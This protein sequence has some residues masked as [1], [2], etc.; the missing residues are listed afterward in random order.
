MQTITNPHDYSVIGYLDKRKVLAVPNSSRQNL[1]IL[2]EL[3]SGKSSILRLLIY[4]DIIANR[5]FLLAEN[6]SELSREV[7]SMIPPDQHHKIVY[8]SLSSIRQ[9]DKTLRFNPL[10]IDDPQD[11]GMI[12]LNFTECLAKAFADSWGARVETCARN[13]AL[14][15]IGTQSNTIGAML[16]LLTDKEFRQTFIPEINNKQARDFFSHVYAEQ[17]PK[18]A[19]GV[20]FNKLNKMLTIPEMDAMFNTKK[21]SVSFL[22]IINNDM[23]V[24]LDFGGL[25]NDMV[26]FLGNV[27]LHLFYTQYKKR[28]KNEFGKYNTFNLYLDEVQ[29]FS[30]P[31]IRELLNTV[32]KYG[33][34]ATIATQSITAVGKEL[35]EEIMT[36]CRA[37]ACFRCDGTTAHHLKSILPIKPEDQQQLSFHYFSYYGAGDKPIRAVAKTKHMNIPD[38]S[39]TAAKTSVMNLGAFVSLDKYYISQGGNLDVILSPLEFGILNLL[40][41][42]NRDMTKQEITEKIRH[43]YAADPRAITNALNDTLVATNSFAAIKDIMTDDGDEKLESRYVITKAA[44]ARIF[45]HAAAGRRAGGDLHL[46]TIFTIMDLQTNLY[47]YCIPDLGKGSSQKADLLIFSPK[48][49]KPKDP[50]QQILQNTRFHPNEWS[51]KVIAVEVETAPGK[52]W[53]Q[54]YNNYI[55]NEKSGYFPWFVVFDERAKQGIHDTLAEHGVSATNYSILVYDKESLINADLSIVRS[56][57][58]TCVWKVIMD[59]RGSSMKQICE[60]LDNFTPVDL[61][62]AV[63]H[64]TE[65]GVL[66]RGRNRKDTFDVWRISA[67]RNISRPDI[68]GTEPI[69][70][71]TPEDKARYHIEK[72]NKSRENL[73]QD[74]V[75][76]SECNTI[77]HAIQNTDQDTSN[78][79]SNDKQH[80]DQDTSQ[81]DKVIE[82]NIDSTEHNSIYK[83]NLK[84]STLND[85]MI[86]TDTADTTISQDKTPNEINDEITN[87]ITDIR[88]RDQYTTDTQLRE[89]WIA[90]HDLTDPESQEQLQHIESELKRRGL[91][92]KSRR[93]RFFVS[94]IPKNK[95]TK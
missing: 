35:S 56:D 36:L 57:I 84:Q 94:K 54:I 18:E 51:D 16:K 43:R 64:M 40:R 92:I 79:T 75:Q 10:E 70:G 2:G 12:A 89:Y 78:D 38:N 62:R 28:S 53:D 42:E 63:T 4:Q 17:Y 20:I 50:K 15:V 60:V 83:V 21:S 6:H 73:V 37:V 9:Y 34:K 5:G 33:I 82:H 27:F 67:M 77:Q 76:A 23:Y 91:M 59:N 46:R 61:K 26:M 31:M 11:A 65:T 52:H 71:T 22:D 13:G 68:F 1:L 80:T 55:K 41:M 58:E 93:G 69:P 45:S 7:L 44:H 88:D 49:I 48:E 32:R 47:C 90:L 29:M 95:K 72:Q 87:E 30:P 8:V 66:E 25:P 85:H 19:G 24:V 39:I 3:G 86:S 14:A 74:T 81:N